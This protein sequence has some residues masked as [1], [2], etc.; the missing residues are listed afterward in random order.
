MK[1]IQ[2]NRPITSELAQALFLL[3]TE[4]CPNKVRIGAGNL[5]NSFNN[6]DDQGFIIEQ[7]LQKLESLQGVTYNKTTSFKCKYHYK[8]NKEL[9]LL[10]FFN[11]IKGLGDSRLQG[12]WVWIKNPNDSDN[13]KGLGFRKVTDK[14]SDHYGEHYINGYMINKRWNSGYTTRQILQK[15]HR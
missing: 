1:I 3:L 6:S 5:L 13:L 7:A 8:E 2:Q 10:N 4:N 9:N 11:E 15:L 12:H 14:N